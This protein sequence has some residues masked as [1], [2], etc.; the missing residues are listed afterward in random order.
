MIAIKHKFESNGIKFIDF[1][2]YLNKI[3]CYIK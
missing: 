3:V 1:V 2:K